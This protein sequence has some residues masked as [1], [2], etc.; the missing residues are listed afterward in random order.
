MDYEQRLFFIFF[1][2]ICPPHLENMDHTKKILPGTSQGV[3]MPS[4][5]LELVLFSRAKIFSS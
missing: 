2:Q 4:E 5:G 1:G 3:L